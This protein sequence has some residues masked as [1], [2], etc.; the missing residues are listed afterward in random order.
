MKRR[1]GRKAAPRVSKR[2]Q[3]APPDR[4]S[5][6]PPELLEH[7]LGF[8]V[9]ACLPKG[10]SLAHLVMQRRPDNS[11]DA[12]QHRAFVVAFK[13][14]IDGIRGTCRR[15]RDAHDTMRYWLDGPASAMAAQHIAG[16][17]LASP[18]SYHVAWRAAVQLWPAQQRK[19]TTRIVPS[20]SRSRTL[21]V[22]ESLRVLWPSRAG[23]VPCTNTELEV[24]HS[25]DA[26]LAATGESRSRD[27]RIVALRNPGSGQI[28]AIKT[29]AQSDDD[30][31]LVRRPLLRQ[32][33]STHRRDDDTRD[34]GRCLV[35]I[36]DRDPCRVA[37]T[38]HLPELYDPDA[39]VHFVTKPSHCWVV[40]A[41]SPPSGCR[42]VSEWHTAM[43]R[44]AI[45]LARHTVENTTFL[46]DSGV[47]Q[48][49]SQPESLL[50]YVAM[51]DPVTHAPLECFVM[52]VHMTTNDEMEEE[53]EEE[54]EGIYSEIDCYKSEISSRSISSS[55]EGDTPEA[56]A[57]M[58]RPVVKRV[59]HL[60]CETHL[61][62]DSL[63]VSRNN[64]FAHRELGHALTTVNRIED[65]LTAF[66]EERER[67]I[68]ANHQR[69][70][71][72][73]NTDKV[74]DMCA[75]ALTECTKKMAA[76]KMCFERF[77]MKK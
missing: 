5:L 40:P 56:S 53:E 58:R 76:A 31:P 16:E 13:E 42:D 28:V 30:V 9:A 25:A 49:E 1:L 65:S 57:E 12:R 72:Y 6:L 37:W 18:T 7:V 51:V 68:I 60:S 27:R 33:G 52:D 43:G 39:G 62:G 50:L 61:V 35:L 19:T 32:I 70:P 73:S 71:D 23:M 46:Q 17:C 26:Y 63:M 21:Y 3:P 22:D 64:Q 20:E 55:D 10:K 74:L 59:E 4:F 41:P 45:T 44:L 66:I 54:D 15:W 8:A 77:M 38:A 69:E 2:H 67:L 24:R 48:T 14:T 34:D 75:Q 11:D 29:I 36:A 47:I